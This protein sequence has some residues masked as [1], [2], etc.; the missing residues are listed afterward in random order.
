MSGTV[1]KSLFSSARKVGL[2]SQQLR[3]LT[4]EMFKYDID[5]DSDLD[6]NDRFSVVVDQTWKEGS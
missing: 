5:F 6:E 3:Q 1:G 4:D 2:G